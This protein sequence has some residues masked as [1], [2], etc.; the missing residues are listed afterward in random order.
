MK[1]ILT[2][3]SSLFLVIGIG[4]LIA[5]YVVHSNYEDF[6]SHADIVDAEVIDLTATDQG[7]N[8]LIAYDYGDKTYGPALLGGYS[9]SMYVGG[10][11]EIYVDRENPSDFSWGSG[12]A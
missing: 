12:I 7:I 9:S 11:V 4:M 6:K 10:K 3:V 8:A 5:A 2:I 1:K